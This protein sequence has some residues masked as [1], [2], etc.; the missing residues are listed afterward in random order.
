MTQDWQTLAKSKRE[1]IL[2]AI[3]K[4]WRLEYIPPAE[5]VRD[6]TGEYLWQFLS[7][8]EKEITETDAELL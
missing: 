7:E 4:E 5:E 3:P 1:A 8:Q 2:A 6:V